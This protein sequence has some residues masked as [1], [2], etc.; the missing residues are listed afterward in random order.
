LV[1]K[2]KIAVMQPY[3]FP[4]IGYWQL[5][6]AVDIFVIYDDVNYIKRGYI[7]RNSILINNEAKR[8]TLS[9][10]KASQNK[11][12]NQIEVGDDGK[13]FLNAI[14]MSYSKAKYFKNVYSLIEEILTQKE[15]NLAKYIGY[16]IIKISE[17]LN[18]NTKIVYSSD[19]DKNNR[20]KGQDKIIDIV[21]T[22]NGFHYINPIGGITLYDKDDFKQEGIKLSFLETK[23]FSYSQFG[24]DFIP[25]LSI[26]DLLMF[27]SHEDL[28]NFLNYY[29]LI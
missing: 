25:N 22:L 9:L 16:S 23:S 29:N 8:I 6:N 1:N 26:I 24:N 15:R 5:I 10:K 13:K 20:L 17:Y 27:N 19:I 12:I 18:I 14:K 21:K 4:Y 3:L 11:L 28:T 2:K 7:N